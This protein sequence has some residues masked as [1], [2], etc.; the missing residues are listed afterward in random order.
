[1]TCHRIFIFIGLALTLTFSSGFAS[2]DEA[3][4]PKALAKSLTSDHTATLLIN[5]ILSHYMNNGIGSFNPFI[6]SAGFEYPK[7]TQKTAIYA[8]GLVWGGFHHN[9]LK[10][11]GSTFHSGLQAGRI[12]IPGT[13]TTPPQADD[14]TL[15][16]YR[17]F[18]VR[19]DINPS[20]P[21]TAVQDEI[22]K[23]LFYISRYES[24]T[25][26]QLYNTYLQDWNEWP[27]EQGAPFKDNNEN[28]IYENS[29]DI[30]GVPG[31]D[32]SLWHVSN[33]LDGIRTTSL[34]GSPPIGLELQRTIWAY[35][36]PG[37]LGKILFTKYI[38]INKSGYAVES[39]YLSFW[40]DIDI[41]GAND[42]YIG[43]DVLTDLGFIYNGV[44][45]DPIY[46][47]APP[48]AGVDFFQGPIVPSQ[49]TD[50]AIFKGKYRYGYRNLPLSSINFH[51]NGDNLYNDPPLNES[52][53]TREWYNLMNGLISTNGAEHIDP[54]TGQPTR[55]VFSGDPVKHRGWIDGSYRPPG[56]R[57]LVMTSGPFTMAHG[58]TQEV[59]LASLVG[60]G[61]DRISSISAMRQVDRIAQ[62]LYN[63]FFTAVPPNCITSIFYPNDTQASVLLSTEGGIPKANAIKAILRR[64]D[65]TAAATFDL[66]DDGMHN[67]GAAGDRIF[68]NTITINRE[69]T[70][71][72]LD[73]EVTSG[74][75]IFIYDH[76][77]ESITTAGPIEIIGPFIFSDHLNNDRISNPG[78]NIRYG[79]TILN[80]TAFDLH[81]LIV[82]PNP[83]E[84]GRVFEI[85]ALEKDHQ[86]EWIYHA[87]DPNSYFSI[88]L[89]TDN[90]DYIY[91]VTIS[92]TD[93]TGNEWMGTLPFPVKKLSI[94]TYG[95]PVT[96]TAGKSAWSFSTVIVDRPVLTDHTYEIS[97]EK[98]AN[99]KMMNLRDLNSGHLL[100]S[101]YPLPDEF[102]HNIPVT[103]GFK[104][105][106]GENWGQA[107]IDRDSTRWISE[108]PLWFNGFRFTQDPHAAFNGG[109]TTGYQLGAIP[110]LGHVTSTFDYEASV[111]VEVRFDPSDRQKAYRLRRT[112]PNT[113]YQLQTSIQAG[114]PNGEPFVDVPLQVWDVSDPIDPRQLTIAWR[115]Q[116]D[117]ASWDPPIG[118]D[119]AEVIF[120]YYRTYDPLC[121]QFTY[122]ANPTRP[123]EIVNDQ[124]TVGAEADIMYGLSISVLE[125]HA[126][127]ENPGILLLTP[128]YGLTTKDR[129]QFR[130][131][132]PP[133][134]PILGG[135]PDGATSQPVIFWCGW[136]ESPGADSYRIQISD[137]DSLFGNIVFDDST[138]TVNGVEISG[139]HL[140]FGETYFWRVNAGNPYGT[141]E[142]STVWKFSTRLAA[143]PSRWAFESQTGHN[144]SIAIP[145]EI[146]P[147]I[148]DRALRTGD[149][150]G[151][152]FERNDSL[153]CAGYSYWKE[154]ESAGITAWGDDDRTAKKDGFATG[155]LMRFKIWDATSAREYTGVVSFENGGGTYVP[156]G[157]YVLRSLQGISLASQPIALTRGWNMI[158]SFVDPLN[159][160]L[161][162]LMADIVPAVT[163]MKNGKGQTFWPSMS[164]NT[165][166]TWNPKDGYQ[167]HMKM[168]D[169]L[170]IS[171][172]EIVPLSNPIYLTAG[173]NLV[174][175]L[176]NDEMSPDSALT[177]ILTQ[178]VIA[179]NNSGQVYWPGLNINTLGQMKPGEGY[180]LYVTANSTLIY[181]LNHALMLSNPMAGIPKLNSHDAHYML[182]IAPTG[183]NAI[184]AI[185]SESFTDG[186]EIAVR[187]SRANLIGAGVVSDG[188]AVVCIRGDDPLTGHVIEGAVESELLSLSH[189]SQK[190][191][192]ESQLVID[193]IQDVIMVGRK[194]GAL[195]YQNDMVLIVD[196]RIDKT[197][198]TEFSLSQ[199]YPNPFNP[200]TIIRYGLPEDSHV[201]LELFNT[202]GQ[203][204]TV[205]VDEGQKA[206]FHQV[207]FERSELSSGIYLYRLRAGDFAKI[208]KMIYIK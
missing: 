115:D 108:F 91:P 196:A 39:M 184:V 62:A 9:E 25:A 130:T 180:Q 3:K 175:Y 150:V 126:L 167:I 74:T 178:L 33:D 200:S 103:H 46:D 122:P 119:N 162:A 38:V 185:R 53:G 127:N 135:P 131:T 123:G 112:G 40:S 71:L 21:F 35:N 165:I 18:R 153:I 5:Q 137:N 48:A 158:S 17:V 133:A 191:K 198:P 101:K 26:Q 142:W 152:F 155:E 94:P 11:G 171:G 29:V 10:V 192:T 104:V 203:R 87:T 141:S 194:P 82:R 190:E 144:A 89:P 69:Y 28:G 42:D 205:I 16:K 106:R 78:E 206:G 134:P 83:D 76:V 7:G 140:N 14:P 139:I 128:I 54:T 79:F 65:E 199:N 88:L 59:V 12:L 187:N 168:P 181:P 154:G 22:N 30:P 166:G 164:I 186:D 195:I 132:I 197:I 143:V 183:S 172:E 105:L 159:G 52:R 182:T 51:N 107:G 47:F 90:R 2:I 68:A 96:H 157:I 97:I 86:H 95:T 43:C 56:D 174:G 4:S 32:Q 23:E 77:V 114:A 84:L 179:K 45:T 148:N 149:A 160:D 111:P 81:S 41:G 113:E 202:L 188:K 163:L 6:G 125:G 20:T 60:S 37:S 70:A 24:Y 49:P 177:T 151:V 116:N 118:N 98:I 63:S 55:F 19:P 67:D 15:F 64:H 136:Q 124:L 207:L 61:A 58:D 99:E 129:F 169:T 93:A 34:Y 75:N 117:N 146:N 85:P 138:L 36:I 109:V 100:L 201:K 66:F 193:H 31:A 8:D 121:R 92:I 72:Y 44:Y 1:M 145:R 189:W 170:L 156:N 27:A 204:L 50:R 110:Y 102:G 120:I 57:R 147:R 73:I 13:S 161:T 176:R 80:Q 208:R 173:W